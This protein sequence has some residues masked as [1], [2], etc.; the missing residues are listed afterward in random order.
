MPSAAQNQPHCIECFGIA[1]PKQ[2]DRHLQYSFLNE[3]LQIVIQIL[4][5]F[6]TNHQMDNKSA[7]VQVMT[8]DHKGV[9]CD[10][11]MHHWASVS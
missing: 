1:T 10:A 5:R 7:L 9:F 3:S 4:F 11:S 2:N 6:I 8:G